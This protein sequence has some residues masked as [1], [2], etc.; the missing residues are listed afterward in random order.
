MHD[1]LGCHI[2]AGGHSIGVRRAGFNVLA[3]LEESN[4]GA[5]TSRRNLGVEVRYGIDKWRAQEFQGRVG[6]LYGNPP[7]AAWSSLG[8]RTKARGQDGRGANDDRARCTERLFDLID[9]V[10]PTVFSW[11]CVTNALTH[12]REFVLERARFCLERGYDVH[13]IAF[14]AADLGLPSR[15]L[16]MFFV[17]S[18]VDFSIGMNPV[19]RY[20]TPREALAG[21]TDR[22]P[23][24]D[25]RPAY[26]AVLR[27]MPPG[28]GVPRKFCEENGLPVKFPFSIKRVG[29]DDPA[30]WTIS[31]SAHLVHPDEPRFL[32]VL[33]Q[34]LLLGYPPDYKFAGGVAAQ[35][36]QIGCAVTP[37]ASEWLARAVKASLDAPRLVARP[38]LRMH[39]LAGGKFE[40]L[41]QGVVDHA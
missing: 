41:Y 39:D 2:Y 3:H 24:G 29:W 6:W 40:A 25:A 14:Q 10:E 13:L 21:V 31:G 23:G 19:A 36:K 1:A 4:F 38:R 27:A 26:A 15:R 35:Y 12:G 32:S 34:Q 30:T 28:R 7:C 17:A 9:V 33:E 11:E 18:L 5:E 20:V 8:V 16:R 22:G 37:A